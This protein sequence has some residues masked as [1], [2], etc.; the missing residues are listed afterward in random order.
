MADKAVHMFSSSQNN[1]F[2][3]KLNKYS[4]D[5]SVGGERPAVGWGVVLGVG[6]VFDCPSVLDGKHRYWFLQRPENGIYTRIF[7]SN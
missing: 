1:P 3:E 4:T 7:P 2:S 6:C 5:F